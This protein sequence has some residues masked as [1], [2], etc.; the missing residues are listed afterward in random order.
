MQYEMYNKLDKILEKYR[1]A[2]VF[3]NKMKISMRHP[4]KNAD[5]KK[6][7]SLR[8]NDRENGVI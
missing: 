2:N 3:Q 4:K 5:G 8:G 7:H 1:E 6:Q